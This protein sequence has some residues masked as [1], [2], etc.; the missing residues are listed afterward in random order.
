MLYTSLLTG[1]YF[2]HDWV[3]V[4]IDYI[5][6]LSVFSVPLLSKDIRIS[7]ENRAHHSLFSTLVTLTYLLYSS[8]LL[9]IIL[10]ISSPFYLKKNGNTI[11]DLYIW[12]S[13]Y[14]WWWMNWRYKMSSPCIF[15]IIEAIG[16]YK[17]NMNTTLQSQ[18]PA[19][20]PIYQIAE[21]CR[22]VIDCRDDDMAVDC[23][24]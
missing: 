17:H 10:Y 9:L 16:Q 24:L 5:I 19:P 12:I 13:R 6:L 2:M 8:I 21:S 11:W 1:V 23:L 3:C 4:L 22:L 15:M 18:A 7:F 20:H 14:H